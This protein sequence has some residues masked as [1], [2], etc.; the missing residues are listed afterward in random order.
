MTEKNWDLRQLK[1]MLLAKKCYGEC[2]NDK[3]CHE[4]RG[5]VSSDWREL[6]RKQNAG[7]LD[8][9]LTETF[10]RGGGL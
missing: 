4:A 7:K 9:C 2:H 1:K 3:N 6:R 8:V 10:H 5:C